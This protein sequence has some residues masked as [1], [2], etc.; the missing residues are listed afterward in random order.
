MK[1]IQVIHGAVNC[2]YDLFQ[3]TEEEF[4]NIFPAGEAVAFIDEVYARGETE[5]LEQTLNAI[6]KRRI[7]KV[8]ALGIHGLLFYELEAK[9]AYCPSR[10]DEEASNQDGN[11]LR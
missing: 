2:V 3:A 8:Q 5:I 11:R 9:K 10:R 4:Q 6:W 1:H 7:P